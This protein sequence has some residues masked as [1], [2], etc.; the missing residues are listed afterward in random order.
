MVTKVKKLPKNAAVKANCTASYNA[1]PDGTIL[2]QAE[3]RSVLG[4]SCHGGCKII[5]H[6]ATI[7]VKYL[8][9]TPSGERQWR[10]P[11]V[12]RDNEDEEGED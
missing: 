9:E 2:D 6:E 11:Q 12:M 7:R 8:V 10:Y 4:V 5:K 3:S 1:M